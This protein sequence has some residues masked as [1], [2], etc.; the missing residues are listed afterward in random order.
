MNLVEYGQKNTKTI[1]LL[2]GGGLSWWNYREV[3][4]LLQRDYHV[5]LPILDGHSGSDN[6]FISIE[7]NALRIITYID[8]HFD[9]KVLLIGGLSLG[10]QILVEILSQRKDIC[11]FAIVESALVLP[12]KLTHHLLEPMLNI[13][14]GLISKPWFAKLQ[15]RSLKMKSALFID[16]FADSCDITKENMITFLKANAD[17]V[18]KTSLHD[19]LAKVYIFVGQKES[20]KMRLSAK[21]LCKQIPHSISE[22]KPGLYHGEFSINHAEEYAQTLQTII[23]S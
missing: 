16:Y 8:T 1:I 15:F 13:S 22:M 2:H 10:A 5:I 12:M 21:L 6:D 23:E 11:E 19:T 9:G 7:E 17:Y 3:A 14:F 20:R 4:E 18:I